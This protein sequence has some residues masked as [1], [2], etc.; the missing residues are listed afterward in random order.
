MKPALKYID[1]A[2][3]ELRDQLQSFRKDIEAL[4][5]EVREVRSELRT[6]ECKVSENMEMGESLRASIT[7]LEQSCSSA[8]EGHAQLSHNQAQLVDALEEQCQYSRKFTLLLSGRVVPPPE[9]DEDT[10]GVAISLMKDYLGV[11]VRSGEIT[12]CHRLQSKR[13]ILV[14]FAYLD[15][16][17]YVYSRR[18]RPER[19]GLLVHESLTPQRLAVVKV[20]QKL[21]NPKDG[22]PFVSYY[23]NSGRIFVR[24]HNSTKA[25]EVP[26]H[27]TREDILQLCSDR[28]RRANIDDTVPKRSMMSKGTSLPP[29]VVG[30]TADTALAA[31]RRTR[32][33]GAVAGAACEVVPIGGPHQLLVGGA[34]CGGS[35]E[36]VAA[37]GAVHVPCPADH[38]P[39]APAR[40]APLHGARGGDVCVTVVPSASVPE[41]GA[42]V[43][44][45]SC[46]VVGGVGVEGRASVTGAGGDSLGER[47]AAAGLTRS[48]GLPGRAGI[49]SAGAGLPSIPP[50][51]TPPPGYAQQLRDLATDLVPRPSSPLTAT[52]QTDSV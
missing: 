44:V 35:G 24:L 40:D 25:T 48:P 4:R 8:L 28:G 52:G 51:L 5:G 15:Q 20:L 18:V 2:I 6:C 37:G 21:H 13:V 43:E 17:M 11:T 16:R 26:V 38:A 49:S 14:R 36:P 19:R 39:V 32:Q 1:T 23:T 41:L 46:G 47:G 45:P 50:L 31:R 29:A 27:S 33:G 42:T 9:R 7:N 22:S 34:P 10:R 3:E 30:S 12:A